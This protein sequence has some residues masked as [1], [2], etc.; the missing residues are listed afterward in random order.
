[1]SDPSTAREETVPIELKHLVLTRPLCV[2]DLESTGSD[3]ATDRVV[4]VAVVSIAPDGTEDL[5]ATRVNPGRPIPAAAT[6]IH[7]IGDAD[8]RDAPTFPALAPAL[9][10]RLAGCDLAGF[11]IVG[12][13]L[14]LLAAEFGRAGVPFALAG[15]AVLDALAVYRRFEAR[16]LAAAVGFYL[17]REHTH[18]HAAAA[19]AAAAAEVLDRQ[20]GRYGLPPAPVALHAALVDVDVG[21]KFRRTPAGVVV[22]GFGKHAGRPLAEVARA[23]PGYLAWMLTRP[24]LD[25]AHALVRAA[26]AAARR[27]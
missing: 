3:P 18:A 22:F 14:P 10:R 23:D 12:F 1:M 9:A 24:F 19:D 4:E 11:G 26:A 2:V 15:R 21:G 20:V 16:T 7:G 6:A 13:D 17:G 5:F 8:V 25:D 27:R